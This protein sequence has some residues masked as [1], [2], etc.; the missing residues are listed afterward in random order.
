MLK[1][2][3]GLQLCAIFYLQK[4]IIGRIV[5]SILDDAIY[6]PLLYTYVNKHAIFQVISVEHCV[7]PP[8]DVHCI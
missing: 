5:R 4:V 2:T 3:Q 8:T 1:R 6:M 7:P